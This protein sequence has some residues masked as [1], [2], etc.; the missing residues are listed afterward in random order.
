MSRTSILS[1]VRAGI[2]RK[3]ASDLA[4]RRSVAEWMSAPPPHPRPALARMEGSE[5]LARFKSCLEQQG[6]A[7]ITVD[8][9]SALPAAVTAFLSSL[10][11]TP[12][13]VIGDDDRLATLA[14][15]NELVPQLWRP[16][17]TLGDGT[18]ALT[19][20]VAGV[21]ETGTLILTSRAASPASLAFLPE[22]H[23]VALAEADILASFEETF[24]RLRADVGARRF[25]RAVNM[26]SGASRTGD[27]GGKIV[28]G[29]HGPRR[30][31]VFIYA[32]S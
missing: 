11:G 25:P 17:E 20:A 28:K 13:L 9:L 18:A 27:I 6:T 19:H 30:L 4:R 2:L 29:A 3:G 22:V 31:A 10:G 14:W 32:E 24:A 7:I 5:R 12:H 23:L 21:A 26:I 15:P 16:G 8:S 1:R